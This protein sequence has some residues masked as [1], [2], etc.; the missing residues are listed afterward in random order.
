MYNFTERGIAWGGIAKNYASVPDYSSP[1]DVVPPPNWRERYPN[2]YTDSLPNLHD[3]EHF[4][5]WMR[6]AALPTFRKLWARNDQEVM[7]SGRY[8]IVANMSE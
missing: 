4:Q 7:A 3:D 6:I 8:Q 5:V 2:G 1:S